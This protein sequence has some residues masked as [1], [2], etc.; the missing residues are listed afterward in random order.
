MKKNIIIA[1]VLM[2]IAG[3]SGLAISSVNKL[4]APIIEENATKK[5]RELCVSIFTAYD[6][7]KSEVVDSGFSDPAIN[8]KIVAK[9]NNGN[10]LGYIYSVSGKNAY[11]NIALLVGISQELKLVSVEFLENGQSFASEVVNH[12][13]DSYSSGIDQNDVLDIDTSCGATFGAKTVQELVNIAFKDLKG[14]AL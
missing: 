2:C 4:T 13:N 6:E 5:E 10:T 8:K 11:G 14:G 12:V 9:D 1:L 7:E 3:L